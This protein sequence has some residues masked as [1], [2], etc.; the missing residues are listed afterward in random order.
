LSVDIDNFKS[1]NDWYGHV[2]GDRVLQAV[3]SLL[4]SK[5]RSSDVVARWGGDE[6]V[7]LLLHTNE[8]NALSK[9]AAL[10][11]AVAALRVPFCEHV[12][13][14]TVSVGVTVIRPE[15][16]PIKAIKRADTNML[17]RKKAQKPAAET[18]GYTRR[19]EG[20]RLRTVTG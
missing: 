4:V 1:I 10:E 20:P 14:A 2:A 6:L 18:A 19:D 13:S 8:S 12:L 11:G 9:A 15:D 3:A 17:M 7:V 5:V 16:T